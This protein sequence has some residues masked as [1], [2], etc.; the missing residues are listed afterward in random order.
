MT[1]ARDHIYGA[2]RLIGELAEG[3]TPSADT[4]QDALTAMNQM[5]DA[6]SI[7]RL[8]VYSV[9]DQTISWTANNASRT[10]GATGDLVGT[11]PIQLLPST[12][13][14]DTAAN[15]SFG[16]IK[17]ITEQEY[18]MI[19]QKDM[20]STYPS[21]LWVSMTMPNM[22]LTQYP[23]ATTDLAWHFMS[24]VPLTQLTTLATDISVPSGYLRMFR[25]NLAVEIASE[26]G[27]V[28]PGWVAKIAANS[29]RAVKRINKIN[30]RMSLPDGLT[31]AYRP[32]IISG[33]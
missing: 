26:F 6:M 11:R 2:L 24:V 27:I 30:M 1:T 33:V 17:F 25:F 28:P 8:N 29:K 19:A 22:T 21:V 20:T 7:E 5:I 4:A 23:V 32:D 13:Y 14:K 18:N 10:M 3:E 9:Q 16:P 15:I 31:N 12:Y